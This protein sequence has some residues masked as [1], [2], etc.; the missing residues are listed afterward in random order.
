MGA[1]WKVRFQPGRRS[2]KMG[3]ENEVVE[4]RQRAGGSVC[5]LRGSAARL[6]P[7][8]QVGVREP[9]GCPS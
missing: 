8:L 3:M 9:P 4:K 2:D 5:T 1:C 7:A 6:L